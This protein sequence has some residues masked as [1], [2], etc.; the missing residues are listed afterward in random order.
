ML[1]ANICVAQADSTKNQSGVKKAPED[2]QKILNQIKSEES[3]K[4][5]SD[6][7][8]EI[9]GLLVDET[10]T[11]NGRDFYDFFYS[12]WEAPPGANN[13]SIFITEKPYRLTTTMIEVSINET[14]VYQSF[15]QPRI[16]I[17]E[18][19][20]EEAVGRTVLYMQNYEALVKQMEGDDRSGS[21]I[22]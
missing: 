11:K 2:L 1:L 3:E 8:L 19:L 17:I 13:Y 9:D 15:L 12:Q 5:S 16:D 14:L 4:V 22:F 6:A 10:K 20:A 18:M 7:D 21:G